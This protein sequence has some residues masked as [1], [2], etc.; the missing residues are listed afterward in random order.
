MQ[1]HA[2]LAE[3]GVLDVTSQR[4]AELASEMRRYLVQ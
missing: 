4:R 3:H 2:L 1:D